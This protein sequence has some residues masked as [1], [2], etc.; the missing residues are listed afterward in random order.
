[1]KNNTIYGLDINKCYKNSLHYSKYDYP[2]FSV[3]DKP[4]IYDPIEINNLVFNEKI[5]TDS[6]IKYVLFS[7]L[8]IPSNYYNE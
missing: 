1:M 2:L 3:M 4:K 8:T 7:S 5:I 6:D